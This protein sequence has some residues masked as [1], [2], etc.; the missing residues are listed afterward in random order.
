[1]ISEAQALESEGS[2]SN[3]LW[4]S[5]LSFYFGVILF[6]TPFS[7]Q[8]NGTSFQKPFTPLVYGTTLAALEGGW[9]FRMLNSGVSRWTFQH[10]HSKV[11]LEA[12]RWARNHAPAL[13]ACS[14]QEANMKGSVCHAWWGR[15]SAMTTME[16]GPSLE[17][18][19]SLK[20]SRWSHLW[21]AGLSQDI[22][23][24]SDYETRYFVGMHILESWLWA[25]P[26]LVKADVLW[27]KCMYFTM[28]LKHHIKGEGQAVKIA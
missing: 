28:P 3:L 14:R 2:F 15:H 20:C 7:H 21:V 6:S 22:T 24:T 27:F 23:S 26:P 5:L 10:W 11:K 13:W 16:L 18:Q 19:W 17:D 25:K 8:D 4:D 1:M 12:R 9:H